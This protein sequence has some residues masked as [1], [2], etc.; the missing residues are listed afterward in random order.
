[1]YI[2]F[3]QA[4]NRNVVRQCKKTADPQMAHLVFT[5]THPNAENQKSHFFPTL[6]QQPIKK[7][8]K[9]SYKTN[10]SCIFDKIVKAKFSR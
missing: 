5:D 3:W 8:M 6:R 10:I 4:Q 2:L 9:Y 1:M 7:L